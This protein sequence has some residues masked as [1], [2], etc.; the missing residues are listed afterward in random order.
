MEPEM[1]F[2]PDFPILFQALISHS[3]PLMVMVPVYCGAL[4]FALF[5]GKRTNLFSLSYCICFFG[6]LSSKRIKL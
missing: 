3:L 6:Y 5:L 4:G 2:P 1:K